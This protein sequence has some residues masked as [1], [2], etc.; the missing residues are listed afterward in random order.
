MQTD[1][2]VFSINV[3]PLLAVDF[4]GAQSLPPWGAQDQPG[5]VQ[6]VTLRQLDSRITARR[7]LA[8]FPW[9]LGEVSAPVGKRYSEIAEKL[10]ESFG[11][12]HVT[13]QME[14]ETLERIEQ[15]DARL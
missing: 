12:E 8:F 6:R 3:R 5:R 15:G 13:L 4:D 2:L 14:K 1:T 10:K 7:G 9:G 11:I